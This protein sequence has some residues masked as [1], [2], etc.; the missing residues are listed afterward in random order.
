MARAPLLCAGRTSVRREV[1]LPLI[2]TARGEAGQSGGAFG[3][4]ALGGWHASFIEAQDSVA[5]FLALEAIAGAA[6][7]RL[8]DVRSQDAK[9]VCEWQDDLE[10]VWDTGRL[11]IQVKGG[12]VDLADIRYAT[13]RFDRLIDKQSPREAPFKFRISATGGIDSAVHHLLQHL[14]QL[15]SAIRIRDTREIAQIERDFSARWGLPIRVARHLSIDTRDMRRDSS[16]AR[17][18]FASLLRNALPIHDFT[19]RRIDRLY[20]ELAGDVF[21]YARRHRTWVSLAEVHDRLLSQFLPLHLL[22]YDDAYVRTDFGYLPDPGREGRLSQEDRLIR[23][24]KRR[25]Y[26][27][28]ARRRWRHALL[29]TLILGGIRCPACNHPLMSGL[30]GIGALGC[31]DCG[32]FPYMTLVYVCDCAAVVPIERQPDLDAMFVTA[33][34]RLRSGEIRCADCGQQPQF[35]K[36]RTR[37]VAVGIPVPVTEY[38]PSALIA[39][40]E[41]LGWRPHWTG[42]EHGAAREMLLRGRRKPQAPD[43]SDI[44]PP[45]GRR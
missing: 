4:Q 11:Y 9:V 18:L 10:L 27:S 29:E 43:E 26:R 39:N 28:W 15:Q 6:D 45:G 38:D 5:S 7:T 24:A 33:I 20:G 34:S 41:R 42:P 3:P 44:T 25:L 36:L 30:L 19:D 40:R 12:V 1:S 23:R 32:Y 22:D 37:L 14:A 17:A 21:A 31:P 2:V 35:E 16:V 8:S 13:R